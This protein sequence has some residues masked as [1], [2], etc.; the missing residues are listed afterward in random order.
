MRPGGCSVPSARCLRRD[1][2]RPHAKAVGPDSLAIP[3]TSFL[4]Q[5]SSPVSETAAAPTREDE[6]VEAGPP[7]APP[8][9]KGGCDMPPWASQFLGIYESRILIQ[10]R[11]SLQSPGLRLRESPTYRGKRL[12]AASCGTPSRSKARGKGPWRRTGSGQSVREQKQ[13]FGAQRRK[14]KALL[15]SVIS[16]VGGICSSPS[17]LHLKQMQTLK[18]RC[19]G[20]LYDFIPQALWS[21]HCAPGSAP[22]AGGWGWGRGIRRASSCS[23]NTRRG[24]PGAGIEGATAV[25]SVLQTGTR[26]VASPQ[27]HAPSAGGWTAIGC[28]SKRHLVKRRTKS[29]TPA[30]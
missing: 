12:I 13:A 14:P 27:N 5:G 1:R 10:V 30:D 22:G 15:C 24:R 17:D 20:A 11:S 2:G 28:L 16:R 7:T 6:E 29:P 25:D 9:P 19:F 4:G 8:R 23:H 21:T 18:A 3:A 26:Q